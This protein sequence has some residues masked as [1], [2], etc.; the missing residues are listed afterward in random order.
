M[1]LLKRKAKLQHLNDPVLFCLD[2]LAIK[3]VERSDAIAYAAARFDAAQVTRARDLVLAL[4]DVGIV[5]PRV[6]KKLQHEYSRRVAARNDGE[7]ACIADPSGDPDGE[8]NA[9]LAALEET[10]DAMA[11]IRRTIFSHTGGK[12]RRQGKR[13]QPRRC[14]RHSITPPRPAG[15]HLQG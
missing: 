13:K 4:K 15:C 7:A 2:V 11:E 12:R 14:R 8:S 6:A 9:K 1:Q 5:E 3:K 10:Y